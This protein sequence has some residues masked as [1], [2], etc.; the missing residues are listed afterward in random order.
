[1]NKGC[2]T[3]FSFSLYKTWPTIY[4]FRQKYEFPNYKTKKISLITKIKAGR[5]RRRSVLQTTLL[6]LLLLLF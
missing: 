6:L 1:M 3:F 2:S 4:F 5:S